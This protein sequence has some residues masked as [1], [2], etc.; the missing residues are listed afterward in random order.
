MEGT[1]KDFM[2]EFIYLTAGAMLFAAGFFIGRKSQPEKSKP[3]D[4][5]PVHPKNILEAVQTADMPQ[6]EKDQWLNWLNYDGRKQ[7]EEI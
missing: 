3:A 5:S 6:N 4:A 1:G 2:P 7:D